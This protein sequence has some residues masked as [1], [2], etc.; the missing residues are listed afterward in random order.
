MTESHEVVVV[1]GPS[2]RSGRDLD[3]V[4]RGQHGHAGSTR[5]EPAP[6]RAGVGRMG[7]GHGCVRGVRLLARS[8]GPDDRSMGSSL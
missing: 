7:R 1:R 2:A 4:A 8:P 5:G 3:N 6:T